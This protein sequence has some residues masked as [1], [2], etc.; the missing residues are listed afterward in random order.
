M[1]FGQTNPNSMSDVCANLLIVKFENEILLGLYTWY[2]GESG[3]WLGMCTRQFL[4]GIY[5]V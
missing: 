5:I 1:E 3:K 2:V 4:F